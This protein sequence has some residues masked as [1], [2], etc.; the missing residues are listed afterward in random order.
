VLVFSDPAPGGGVAT[1]QIFLASD[2]TVSSVTLISGGFRYSV[3]YYPPIA[4]A[5]SSNSYGL[6]WGADFLVHYGTETPMEYSWNGF[7][8]EDYNSADKSTWP[9]SPEYIVPIPSLDG[10]IEVDS[11]RRYCECSE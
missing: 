9:V 10:V 7:I 3:P 8:P 6:G 11:V 5:D 1:G 4:G 2:G